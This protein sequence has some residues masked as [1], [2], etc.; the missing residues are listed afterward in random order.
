MLNKST[1]RVVGDVDPYR[2]VL[3]VY[4]IA[5]ILFVL[6]VRFR[7]IADRPYAQQ[8]ISDS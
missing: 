1:Y 3:I 4:L 7:A 8:I 2:F 5:V 6:T